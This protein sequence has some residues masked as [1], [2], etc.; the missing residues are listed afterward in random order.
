MGARCLK[1]ILVLVRMLLLFLSPYLWSAMMGR[2]PTNGIYLF[3][4]F[5]V[6]IS[7]LFCLTRIRICD[8]FLAM[9][10]LWDIFFNNAALL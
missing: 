7:R 6:S 3:I 5:K 1:P 8:G 10:D 4:F 9:D 2:W